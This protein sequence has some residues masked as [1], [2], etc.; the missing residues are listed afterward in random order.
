MVGAELVSAQARRAQPGFVACYGCGRRQAP[1]RHGEIARPTASS[2]V[3]WVAAGWCLPES[4]GRRRRSPAAGFRGRRR[5][6]ILG[7]GFLGAATLFN[8]WHWIWRVGDACQSVA[9]DLADWQ[10]SPMSGARRQSLAVV[11]KN[12]QT[13]RLRKK[14]RQTFAAVAAD[15]NPP[16]QSYGRCRSLESSA[17]NSPAPPEI[18][19]RRPFSAGAAG[20]PQT[21]PSGGSSC[22]RP[23]AGPRGPSRSWAA[24]G[25]AGPWPGR[26]RRR[27]SPA[28]GLRAAPRPGGRSPAW[29]GR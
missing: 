5:L 1:P 24:P 16:P 21:S 6:P 4:G 15:R 12:W 8:P 22:G 17:A 11:A 19:G 23:T 13:I 7:V 18:G 2:S 28:P 20:L 3:A 29:R 27:P 25:G 26:R 14:R 10:R 9:L